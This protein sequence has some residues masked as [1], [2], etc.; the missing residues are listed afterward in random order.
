MTRLPSMSGVFPEQDVRIIDCDTG[1]NLLERT[2][3]T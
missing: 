1:A 2:G 3:A